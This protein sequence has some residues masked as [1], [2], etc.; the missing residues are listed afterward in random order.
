[1]AGESAAQEIKVRHFS[2]VNFSCVRIKSFL[3]PDVVN[4]AVAGVG[5][6]VDLTV[7][8]ALEPPGAGQPRPEAPDSREHIK[9]AY[10]V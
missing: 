8:D 2:G 6:L 1:M 5:V 4:G 9:I 10:Q 7:S 3:L